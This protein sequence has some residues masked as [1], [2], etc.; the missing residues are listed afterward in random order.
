M[1]FFQCFLKCLNR[2]IE[3]FILMCFFKY[4]YWCVFLSV[5][6]DV[7]LLMCFFGV[8]LSM[9]F[10]SDYIDIVMW[11]LKC[12][13]KHVNT[14]AC[15]ITFAFFSIQIIIQLFLLHLVCMILSYLFAAFIVY[16]TLIKLAASIINKT[17]VI[18][19]HCKLGGLWRRPCGILIAGFCLCTGWNS[20][21]NGWETGAAI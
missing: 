16:L 6:I 9:C 20:G 17:L 10:W 14:S 8:F 18:S 12:L 19:I 13:L 11:S 15:I 5:Y 21:W 4:L 1:C 7:F 2:N 3:V